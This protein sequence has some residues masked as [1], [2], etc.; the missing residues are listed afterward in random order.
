MWISE[1]VPLYVTAFLILAGELIWLHPVMVKESKAIGQAAFMAPFFSNIIMLFLGGLLLSQAG[2]KYRIDNW[3]A[4]VVLRVVGTKP[5]MILLGLIMTSAW[6]SMWM[7]NTAT[8]A[9]MLII[10]LAIV[11]KLE[12]QSS[13][14]TKAI[15]LGVPFACNIGG[16]ATPVG[17]PPNA[18]AIAFLQ[19]A[20][21]HISFHQW[22]FLAFP[23]ALVLLF[24]L[25]RLLLA[26]Y[27]APKERIESQAR[28]SFPDNWRA[29]GTAFIFAAAVVLWLTG[30]WHGLSSGVVGLLVTIALLASNIL[31]SKEFRSLSWDILFLVGGGISLGIAMKESGLSEWMIQ[32]FPLQ[33]LSLFWLLILFVLF[34]SWLTTFMS[35]T[36]TSNIIIPLALS[37][38]IGQGPLAVAIALAV[39]TSMS[40]PVS[41]PP[42]AIAYYSGFFTLKDMFKTGAIISILSAVLILIFALTYWKWVGLY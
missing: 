1:A 9:M 7:S 12:N 37:L 36:A 18:I 20:G 38:S 4:N 26:F 8:T 25:W 42:N 22:L 35:N 32:V 16:M 34:G 29:Y 41:T 30:K 6:L 3:L 21:I 23:I 24:L 2:S 14:F 31:S 17:S 19:K 11:K 15:F 33:G 27:P 28:V 5:T 40:L 10:A 39:S 13:S